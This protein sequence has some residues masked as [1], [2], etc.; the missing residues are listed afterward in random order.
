MDSIGS[1][2]NSNSVQIFDRLAVSKPSVSERG[3]ASTAAGAVNSNGP[4]LI[5]RTMS[6][7]TMMDETDTYLGDSNFKSSEK[8]KRRKGK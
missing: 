7:P 4:S 3:V 5:G 6:C 2:A 1:E 8:L